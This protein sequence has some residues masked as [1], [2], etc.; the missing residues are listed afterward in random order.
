MRLRI[1]G[2]LRLPKPITAGCKVLPLPSWMDGSLI[3]LRD[4][5]LIITNHT[6]VDNNE[7]VTNNGSSMQFLISLRCHRW[8]KSTI[9]QYRRLNHGKDV[10][11]RGSYIRASHRA[12]RKLYTYSGNI[13]LSHAN[14]FLHQML[15]AKVVRLHFASAAFARHSTCEFEFI[16]CMFL[17]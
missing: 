17:A 7:H 12:H 4:S 9:Y 13:Q 16:Y 11:A 3:H 15:N 2:N 10:T 1:L 8:S 5:S 14:H 6:C